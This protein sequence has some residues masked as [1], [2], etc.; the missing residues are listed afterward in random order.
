MPELYAGDSGQGPDPLAGGGGGDEGSNGNGGR[1]SRGGGW[2]REDDPY[3]MMHDWGDH[4][5][6]WWTLGAAALF[7]CAF[8]LACMH[9]RFAC[10]IRIRESSLAFI[11]L[12]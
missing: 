9:G 10:L 11:S 7:A 12:G 8:E 1:W 4:P 5:M 6:R 3:W 2:W